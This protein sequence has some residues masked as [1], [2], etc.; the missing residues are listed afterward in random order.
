MCRNPSGTRSNRSI[1]SKDMY[2]YKIIL[3]LLMSAFIVTAGYCQKDLENH[4]TN[5][6]SGTVTEA[7]FVGSTISVRTDQGQR[8][9]SVPNGVTIV[10]DTHDIALM[11]I[12]EGHPVTIQYYTSSPGKDTVVSIVDNERIAH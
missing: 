3:S 8:V 2:K 6:I 7:D 5:T 9:F 4:R 12:K 1:K 11:D 10:R